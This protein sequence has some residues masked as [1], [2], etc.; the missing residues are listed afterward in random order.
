VKFFNR[1]AS[2]D[3]PAQSATLT[4]VYHAVRSLAG[5]VPSVTGD[6]FHGST[7]ARGMQGAVPSATGVLTR[8]L[9][10]TTRALSGLFDLSP[11]YGAPS[12]GTLA[13]GWY[14]QL[15]SPAG[16][17]TRTLG[18]NRAVA[19]ALEIAS[20]VLTRVMQVTGPALSGALPAVTGILTRSGSATAS[21][22]GSVPAVT[23]ALFV[24]SLEPLQRVVDGAAEVVQIVADA[25]VGVLV[26]SES[27][28]IN[29]A[30]F[31]GLVV[32]WYAPHGGT[33]TGVFGV[34]S[35]GMVTATVTVPQT[36]ATATHQQ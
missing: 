19:G 30:S 35:A 11:R 24:S 10:V 23:G 7:T 36:Y 4:R 26:T 16:V 5:A 25:A 27:S 15:A 6:L 2:G 21:L 18:V 12:F 33:S 9:H 28:S 1:A 8:A 31:G 17:L 13:G 22:A 34:G 29:A 3:V 32:G 20:G 14:S